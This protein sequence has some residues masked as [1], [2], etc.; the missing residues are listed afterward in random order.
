MP[1]ITHSFT[2][3]NSA[4]LNLL[5]YYHLKNAASFYFMVVKIKLKN[6]DKYVLLDHEVYEALSADVTFRE[7][8]VLENLREHS[9]GV[10]VFQKFHKS[11]DGKGKVESIYI[12]A[13]VANRYLPKPQAEKKLFV[14]HI[15]GDKLDCRLRNLKW[16]TMMNV[17]RHREISYNKTGFRGV[18]QTIDDR[19]VAMI[20]DS[21][22][23]LYLGTFDTAEEAAL[24]YNKKS[25]ELFGNTPSLN[26][27]TPEGIPIPFA[28][29]GKIKPSKEKK[30]KSSKEKNPLLTK[31]PDKPFRLSD[32]NIR[33]DEDM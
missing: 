30:R 27:T 33:S 8:S 25:I 16:D 1:C 4:A 26:K 6:D 5:N 22:K 19:F 20:S 14:V 12:S 21:S 18:R 11:A 10:P 13:I 17:S 24:A 15:N 3:E 23:Q 32:G 2:F 7:K 28:S 29:V 31:S 9:S